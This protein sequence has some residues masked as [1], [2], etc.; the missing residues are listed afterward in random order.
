MLP[1]WAPTKVLMR[2]PIMPIGR[3]HNKISPEVLTV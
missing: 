3:E 2:K 1:G